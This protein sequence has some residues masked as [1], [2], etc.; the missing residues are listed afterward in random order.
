M[1]ILASNSQIRHEMLAAA[2]IAVRIVAPEFD[3]GPVKK[4]H[5]GEPEMLARLLAEG[6]ARSI[7]VAEDA[8]VIGSDSLVTV[9]GRRY[10]KPRDR[11]EAAAHL[12]SFSGRSMALTSAVALARSG[13][14]EWSHAESAQLHVRPLSEKF[15]K[16][17]LDAE[18]PEVGHCVGVFRMEGRGVTLF[19]RIE[20]NHFTILGMPLLPLLSA[21][22]E[23]GALAS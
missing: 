11:E 15:I 1:L 22:R 14:I 20:G 21:L 17:Y 13:K 18:W 3:E 12:R 8:L 10:S 2:G 5:D 23:R 7:T 16:A 6:K 19:E 4:A 9:E